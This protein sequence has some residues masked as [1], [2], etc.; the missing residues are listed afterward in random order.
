MKYLLGIC[1]II[2]GRLMIE[3]G[4][5]WAT[6]GTVVIF[7]GGMCYQKLCNSRIVEKSDV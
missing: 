5:W 7:V 3:A 1:C 6:W 4:G 2:T